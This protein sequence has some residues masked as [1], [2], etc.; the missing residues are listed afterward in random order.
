MTEKKPMGRPP[1]RVRV[2][3]RQYD[4][5]LSDTVFEDVLWPKGWPLPEAG[6]VVSGDTLGGWVEHV[7]FDLPAQRVVIILRP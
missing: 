1:E 4:R 2:Q 3:V 5:R 6:S 7:E